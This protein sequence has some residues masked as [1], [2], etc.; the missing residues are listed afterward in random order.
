M[1]TRILNY[2][3]LIEKEGKT[4][5]ALCPSLGLSD[6]GK[7]IDIA[8]KRIKELIKFHIQ[9]LSELGYP[10]PIEKDSTTLITS[11]EVPMP[12]SIKLSY[13]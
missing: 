10:V 7:T 9:S 6:Y 11:I 8:V 12:S 5:V 2:K 3:I 4:F 13:V 1:E